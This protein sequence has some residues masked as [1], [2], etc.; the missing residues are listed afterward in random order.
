MGM[1]LNPKNTGF[2]MALNSEIYIDKSEIIKQTNKIIN[3]VQRFVCVSRPRRFGK[4]MT[5]EM[6]AAYYSRGCNSRELFSGLKI[7]KADS[8]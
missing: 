8:I 2:Q 6:L 4:S 5:A 1:Y 3:T 7:A